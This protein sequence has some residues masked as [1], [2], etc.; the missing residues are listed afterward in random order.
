M[1][2]TVETSAGKKVAVDVDENEAENT[3]IAFVREPDFGIRML[4]SVKKAA[5][6]YAVC[7]DTFQIFVTTL[8]GKTF[9]LNVKASDTT[10]NVKAKIQDQH[11]TPPDM[12]RL[13]FKG[14]ELR[15][16]LRLRE[17]SIHNGDT[18]HLLLRL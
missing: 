14:T 4:V 17:Y 8:V 1:K 11:G 6:Q 7:E 18:L 3:K 15:G 5:K 10:E 2:I 12:Q 16:N 9:T 13:M